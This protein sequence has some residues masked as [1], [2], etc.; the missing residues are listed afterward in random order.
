[1]AYIV[2]VVLGLIHY[3]DGNYATAESLFTAAL[4]NVPPDSSLRDR[5]YPTSIAR[6]C[7]SSER[8]PQA[9]DGR[10]RRR[11]E[12]AT[13][14]KPDFCRRTGTSPSRTPTTAPDLALD[15]AL[16][17]ARRCAALK[18][19]RRSYWLLGLI[20]ERRGELTEARAAYNQGIALDPGH[21]SRSRPGKVLEAMGDAAAAGEAYRRGSTSG[22]RKP[23]A[24]ARHR[25]RRAPDRWS[26]SISWATPTSTR[27]STAAPSRRSTTSCAS[28]RMAPGTIVIWERLLLAGKD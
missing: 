23:P 27:G 6:L 9:G 1:M 13:Q 15:A 8:S 3:S 25:R 2:A 16:T 28:D 11:P 22:S 26:S 18:R 21:V 10:H 24:A 17:E 14:L 19:T 5:R 12:Q 7:A 20:H 4:D